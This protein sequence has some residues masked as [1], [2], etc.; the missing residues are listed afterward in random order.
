MQNDQILTTE[1]YHGTD[2]RIFSSSEE[3]RILLANLCSDIADFSYQKFLEDGFTSMSKIFEYK[4]KR[5]DALGNDWFHFTTCFQKYDSYKKGSQYY[6]YDNFYLTDSK[7]RAANYA[8]LS[9]VFGERGHIASILY[10]SALKLWD[11][12]QEAEPA[13]LRRMEQFE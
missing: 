13:M 1:L 4:K 7:Q 10:H 11:V 8:R 2:N 9:N 12:K 6:Q 5:G 3:E